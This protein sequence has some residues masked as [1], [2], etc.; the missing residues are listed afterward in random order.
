[1]TY[2]FLDNADK[3][4]YG[5][6]LSCLST[7]TSLKN[8]QYPKA[9]TEAANV[10]SNHH[11][12]NASKINNNNNNKHKDN[13]KGE[14]KNDETPEMSFAML[15]GKC[16]CCRKPGHNSPKCHLTDKI[17]KDEWAINKA[18][19]QEQNSKHTKQSHL[20]TNK[21]TE[22]KTSSSHKIVHHHTNAGVRH[23]SNSTKPKK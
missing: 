4:K 1:M 7:Q 6:L 10:L 19:A 17:P 15:E 13:D 16:Y 21:L 9:I 5:T 12:D 11:W 18:K 3:A 14:D 20:N 22:K 2:T 23:M 8:N